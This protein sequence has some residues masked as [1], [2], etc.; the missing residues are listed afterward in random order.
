MGLRFIS[1]AI[2]SA[3]VGVEVLE[4][5]EPTS[6]RGPADSTAFLCCL[7]L[8]FN[9]LLV[10]S[11]QGPHAN[12]T[13]D[14]FRSGGLRSSIIFRHVGLAFIDGKYVQFKELVASSI[15]V[16]RALHSY[17]TYEF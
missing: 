7:F 17:T 10:S 13:Y 15:P 11:V 1:S 2:G 12:F 14:S 16:H 3:S 8:S 5:W 9:A 6:E 4:G